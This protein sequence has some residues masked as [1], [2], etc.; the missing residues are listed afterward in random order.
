[1]TNFCR[2]GKFFSRNISVVSR[3]GVTVDIKILVLNEQGI[4]LS[5]E[6]SFI[7]QKDDESEHTMNSPRMFLTYDSKNI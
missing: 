4:Y 5:R 1:M 2:N 6:R 3:T 7:F